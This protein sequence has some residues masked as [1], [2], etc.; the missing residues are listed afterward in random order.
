MKIEKAFPTRSYRGHHLAMIQSRHSCVP[1]DSNSKMECLYYHVHVGFTQKLRTP[2]SWY[3][4]I[5]NIMWFRYLLEW[6]DITDLSKFNDRAFVNVFNCNVQS[7]THHDAIDAHSS[8][9]PFRTDLSSLTALHFFPTTSKLISKWY[10]FVIHEEL[11]A[12]NIV[13]LCT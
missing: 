8:R 5:V 11:F 10:V 9:H 7:I 12:L 13:L 6:K 3:L 1:V 2:K 4:N